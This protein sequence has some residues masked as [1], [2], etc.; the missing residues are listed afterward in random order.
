LEKIDCRSDEGIFNFSL[1]VLEKMFFCHAWSNN[2]HSAALALEAVLTHIQER[3]KMVTAPELIALATHLRTENESAK[4]ILYYQAA[5][6][7]ISR[8]SKDPNLKIGRTKS[9]CLGFKY[10]VD[11]LVVN[12][13]LEIVLNYIVPL[14][15]DLIQSIKIQSNADQVEKTKALAWT[16][17]F[18][19]LCHIALGNWLE[20]KL[21]M[22]EAMNYMTKHFQ[23]RAPSHWV[24]GA[25]SHYYGLSIFKLGDNETAIQ[26][27]KR[28]LSY[29]NSAD[30]YMSAEYKRKQIE[31]TE[32][33]LKTVE[34]NCSK[35]AK[36]GK[37]AAKTKTPAAQ[38]KSAKK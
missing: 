18:V 35:K 3:Y 37:V 8:S 6:I 28:T 13:D 15:N 36:Q 22:K 4:A 20:V 19:A 31:M 5:T 29:R 32:T 17:F 33:L 24:Y 21:K 14:M 2:K 7:L 10:L 30:D 27:L 12:K 38:N 1:A 25:S 26:E 16:T 11:T 23:N 9:C 34:A